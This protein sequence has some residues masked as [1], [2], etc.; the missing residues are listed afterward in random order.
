MPKQA[1]TPEDEK[2][3]AEIIDEISHLIEMRLTNGATG[4][5]VRGA[6]MLALAGDF[7]QNTDPLSC[8][9]AFTAVLS[10]V[11]DGIDEK[12]AELTDA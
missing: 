2:V 7:A 9:A 5:Q 3:I 6:M 1:V 8:L 11:R 12:K 4:F 10:E